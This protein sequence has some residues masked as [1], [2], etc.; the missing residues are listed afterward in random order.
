MARG[1]GFTRSASLYPQATHLASDRQGRVHNH[2][3]QQQD[4]GASHTSRP[5]HANYLSSAPVA[6][7]P[8][9]NNV[10]DRSCGRGFRRKE[11]YRPM[12][13]GIRYPDD[14]KQTSYVVEQTNNERYT[15]EEEEEGD[16]SILHA[17]EDLEDRLEDGD[18]DEEQWISTKAPQAPEPHTPGEYAAYSPNHSDSSRASRKPHHDEYTAGQPAQHTASAPADSHMDEDMLLAMALQQ[19]ED[20]YAAALRQDR[21]R[22]EEER[23]R[24]VMQ[25]LENIPDAPPPPPVEEDEVIEYVAPETLE[26]DPQS[27]F[28]LVNDSSWATEKDVCAICF[29]SLA[30]GLVISL[31][32]CEHMFHMDCI[33]DALEHSK[34][35]PTCR[36]EVRSQISGDAPSGTMRI[37]RPVINRVP[38]MN[39]YTDK[40]VIQIEYIIPDGEQREYH[41]FP[42]DPYKGT[43]KIAYLPTNSQGTYLLKRLKFAFRNG[44]TF[45]LAQANDTEKCVVNWASIPHRFSLGEKEF[46]DT[47]MAVCNEALDQLGVPTSFNY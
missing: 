5:Q 3:Q 38:D 23:R 12:H 27:D 34:K 25:L 2:Q 9:R 11:S 21:D 20:N 28:T 41:E 33:D 46:H 14:Q 37:T 40:R 10:H 16:F 7:N 13:G 6:H 15:P 31:R 43:I 45:R 19:E 42:G 39:G 4:V 44:L 47:Y 29:D 22:R 26:V 32:N 1:G 17:L 30:T 18:I 8:P 36:R 24:L 35:C